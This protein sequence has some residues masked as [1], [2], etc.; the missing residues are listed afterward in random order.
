MGSNL[1]TPV[2]PGRDSRILVIPAVAAVQVT[3]LGLTRA[4]DYGRCAAPMM[5][6][7]G[8]PSTGPTAVGPSE[9]FP[10]ALALAAC[11]LKG[12]HDFIWVKLVLV[13][14]ES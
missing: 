8:T 10:A 13:S 6:F 11:P 2:N 14:H 3:V 12:C 1:T 4:E 7:P 5:C 9:C